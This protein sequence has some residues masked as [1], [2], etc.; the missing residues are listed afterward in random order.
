MKKPLILLLLPFLLL[1]LCGVS[2]RAYGDSYTEYVASE[3]GGL[4][5]SS[6]YLESEE[7]N[8][9]KSISIFD[10]TLTL[11]Y[12]AI[13][14]NGNT[15]LRS[16]AG[17][18]AVLI[19][20]CLMGAFRNASSGPALSAAY[21]YISI[22]ALSGVTYSVFSSLF[23]FV[24]SALESLNLAMTSLLPVTASLY[25][26][27]GNVNAAAASNSGLLIFLSVISA[28]SSKV[29]LP[30]LRISF[31]LCLAGA[32]PGS[33]NLSP[34]STLVRNTATTVMAF[35]FS[36]LGF[37]LYLQTTIASANDTFVT[38]S[39]RFASGVF[40][41]VIGNMLGDASK[42]VLASVSV[43]KST[44]GAAGTVL[45]LAAVLPPILVTLIYKLL[46]L[47]C[48]IV[49]RML[50]CERESRFL[51][52]LGGITGVLL[53]LMIGSGAVCLIALAIFIKT[54][55]SA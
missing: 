25:V 4:D 35:L 2:A 23:V 46:L 38:R 54:G 45:V 8:G 53:A 10:K 36:L 31:A 47:L 15:I 55:M 14:D 52:D 9:D 49:A 29:L 13:K 39:V 5:I 16:F 21:E 18:F 12:D 42:T 7:V 22:L 33:V 48:S 11:I 32:M 44:V 30:F 34:I 20:C 3:A 28:I 19:L 43:I 37:S 50:G 41:P 51:Y 17:I 6:E 26:F 24:A 40:I 27:G 1:P